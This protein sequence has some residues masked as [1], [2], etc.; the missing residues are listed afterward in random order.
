[1]DNSYGVIIRAHM[2]TEIVDNLIGALRGQTFSPNQIIIVDSSDKREAFKDLKSSDIL[3]IP[4]PD[5]PFNYSKA[6][7]LGIQANEYAYTLLI[8]S[9]IFIDDPTLIK[10]SVAVAAQNGV[11]AMTWVGLSQ[12]G[13]SEGHVIVDRKSFNGK[14]GLSN[15]MSMVKTVIYKRRPFREEVFSAEDQE[16]TAWYL[17]KMN[18][19]VLRFSTPHF[20]YRNPYH[21]GDQFSE[22]KVF[23]EELSLGHFVR[24]R[25]IYP[26]RIMLRAL[27][28][29]FALLRRRN[30][31][32]RMHF[33]FAWLMTKANFMR[34]EVQSRYF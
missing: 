9:H 1:M 22:L 8:S 5:E 30:D 23:N 28:G 16:W 19:K 20:H 11:E 10:R 25:F 31:R 27:R 26:D 15:S 33:R 14:N 7:N 12:E 29:V 2:R 13:D 4:Y 32:A 21:S 6:L 18:E 34:P 24:R 17:K 3:I